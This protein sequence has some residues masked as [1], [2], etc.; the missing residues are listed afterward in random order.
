MVAWERGDVRTAETRLRRAAVLWASSPRLHEALFNLAMVLHGSGRDGDA[1][2]LARR[3]LALR[4]RLFGPRNGLVGASQ[5][6]LG[7]IELAQGNLKAAEPMLLDASAVLSADFGPTHIATGQA[8]LA[9]AHLRMLQQ[10]SS[11][12]SALIAGVEQGF[13]PSDA[14]HRRLLWQART[15]AAQLQC[16]R[17]GGA[18]EAR[19]VLIQIQGEVDKEMPVSAIHRETSDALRS[20]GG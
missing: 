14:E 6:Q 20:C 11:D 18:G 9:L 13:L 15:L 7:E 2:P 10:R 17:A 19:K 8:Q 12:A 4:Q 1:E 16:R 5:R 3:A